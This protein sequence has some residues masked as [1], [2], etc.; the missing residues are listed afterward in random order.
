MG[1][2]FKP[3]EQTV[4]KIPFTPEEFTKKAQELWEEYQKNPIPRY[5]HLTVDNFMWDVL[6]AAGY[7]ERLEILDQIP[8]TY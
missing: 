2:R 7:E 4:D 5:G 6:Y 3:N 8:M 1:Q